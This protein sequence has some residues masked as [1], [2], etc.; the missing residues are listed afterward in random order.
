MKPIYKTCVNCGIRFNARTSRSLVRANARQ[1]CSRSCVAKHRAT[2][3]NGSN[4]HG[5][6]HG[7][8]VD[9]KRYIGVRTYAGPHHRY[10]LKYVHDLVMEEHI[11][12]KLL[13]SEEVHHINEDKHDNR[14]E[15]LQLLTKSEHARLHGK[16][17]NHLHVQKI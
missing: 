16:V 7:L 14:I 12:R 9:K 8:R 17:R 6:K 15:N 10:T 11:G 5:Y 13:P 4:H 2:F 3:I 1:Y